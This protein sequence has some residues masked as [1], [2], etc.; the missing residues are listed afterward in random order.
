MLVFL[1]VARL[2]STAAVAE[3]AAPAPATSPLDAA[4]AALAAGDFETCGKQAHAALQ[5]GGL[6]VDGTVHAWVLRARCFSLG[7]DVDRAERSY[8][9]ALR[10]QRE[11]PPVDDKAFA[12]AQASLPPPSESLAVQAVQRGADVV[13]LRLEADDLQLV[14]AGVLVRGDDE[15]ARVPLQADQPQHKV[16]GL[17]LD[18]VGA[19]VEDKYG[20]ALLRLPIVKAEDLPKVIEVS[21]E[22]P[23]EPGAMTTWG[24]T[25]LG[26]GIVGIAVAG[27]GLASLGPAPGDEANLWLAGVGG[28]TALFLIGAGLV[29]VDQMPGG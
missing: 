23:A 12:A 27:I 7:G 22:R 13:E 8:A 3:P 17:A 24:V 10:L 29:V 4:E 9:V 20:N 15:V 14:R 16:G 28:S 1:L 19:V 11:L 6:D 26:A 25:A 2:A 18:G 5:R 21:G